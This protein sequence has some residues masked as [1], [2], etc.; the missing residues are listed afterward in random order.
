MWSLPSRS[1]CHLPPN[2]LWYNSLFWNELHSQN[3]MLRCKEVSMQDL[4]KYWW[5]R[6]AHA[7][8]HSLK[9][10]W[11]CKGS[12]KSQQSLAHPLLCWLR[13][14][15]PVA[16]LSTSGT[17]GSCVFRHDYYRAHRNT[18]LLITSRLLDWQRCSSTMFKQPRD[19]SYHSQPVHVC[20]A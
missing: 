17:T 11:K 18:S 3:C 16:D 14:G 10:Q 19:T 8:I 20:I 15:L 7:H 6:D 12:S 4:W 1:F 9:L 2:H 5:H 13:R